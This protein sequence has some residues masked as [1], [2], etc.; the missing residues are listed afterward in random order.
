MRA[1]NELRQAKRA[2]KVA[3]GH[4]EGVEGVG[5]GDDVIRA[6]IRHPDVKRQLPEEIKGVR[7]ECVVVGKIVAG[8]K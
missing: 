4:I 7:V 6:Y 5:I 8:V 2:A 1:M 3:F